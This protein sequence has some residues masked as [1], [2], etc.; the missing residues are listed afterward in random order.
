MNEKAVDIITVLERIEQRLIA[1]ERWQ[2]FSNLEKLRAILKDE[3]GADPKRK[4]AY[5][6]SDG[7]RG[8]R[9]VGQMAGVP[10]ATIQNWW[11][12][13]F[14]MGIMESSPN[15]KGR[16]QKICSLQELGIDVP[17]HSIAKIS[18]AKGPE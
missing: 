5:E 1:L 4:L 17:Q 7:S 3:L 18:D 10:A 12:R 2:R 15:R 13:W 14:T 16:V 11:G 9:E 6:Y 8:Y